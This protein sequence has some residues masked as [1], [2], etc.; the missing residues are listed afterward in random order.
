MPD[1]PATPAFQPAELD[2]DA[3]GQPQSRHYGDVYF[4]RASGLEETR[5]VFLAQNDLA[6]RFAALTAGQHLVIGETGF[7]TGL[8]F[9]CAWQLFDEVAP[10]GA[11]LHFI[12]IEKHPLTHADLARALALWPQLQTQAQPLLEQ[13]LAIHPGF[14]QL[15]F[16]GGRVVLTLLVGDVLEALPSLDARV[17]AWFLDG[18]APAKCRRT[19]EQRRATAKW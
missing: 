15:V 2:W 8:N 14:Q 19:L 16:G 12:S 18:F 5:H 7:G 3:S 13:Y 1:R 9:L 11:R 4:S 17:D 6:R 10:T